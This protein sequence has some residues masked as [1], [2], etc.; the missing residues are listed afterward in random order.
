MYVLRQ[1]KSVQEGLLASVDVPL[2]LIQT[3]TRIWEPLKAL[4]KHGNIQTKSDI[5]V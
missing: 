2:R 3:V 4:A 1:A 5:Q